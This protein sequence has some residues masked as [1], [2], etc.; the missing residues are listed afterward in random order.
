MSEENLQKQRND[1]K[2]RKLVRNPEKLTSPCDLDPSFNPSF[3]S[4]TNIFSA[5]QS[6]SRSSTKSFNEQFP[7]HHQALN[8]SILPAN[9]DKSTNASCST[10]PPSLSTPTIALCRKPS[11]TIKYSKDEGNKT[12]TTHDHQ[13][14]LAHHE[15]IPKTT[16]LNLTKREHADQTS[17][18]FLI[19][20]KSL[21][22]CCL[23][24]NANLA[25]LQQQQRPQLDE[26]SNN[27][28]VFNFNGEISSSSA[29]P[30]REICQPQKQQQIYTQT[31]I[32]QSLNL[33]LNNQ[34]NKAQNDYIAGGH[35]VFN[36]NNPFLNDSFDATTT[37]EDEGG[38]KMITNFFNIDD[39]HELETLFFAEAC[40]AE[41]MEL[42]NQYDLIE[43]Q[44]LKNKRE[45][46]S[47]AS[48]MKI[49][50]VVSP[51]TNK[52]FHVSMRIDF[53]DKY[54]SFFVL[55]KLKNK[56]IIIVIE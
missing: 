2:Q 9:V 46:F 16:D 44:L 49:C 15:K 35:I 12:E 17:N 37:H 34:S 19:N 1:Q 39:K 21:P 10:L 47:N 20:F 33:N 52:L 8:K 5:I 24:N 41:D 36:S 23:I 32:S 4:S 26:Q 29:M 48:T 56:W 28:S 42:S 3:L 30:V 7:P 18:N 6:N 11:V 40:D 45:K 14:L 43:E 25:S 22:G 53:L 38:G 50:L 13:S 55:D 54:K 27:E 51:P 31:P